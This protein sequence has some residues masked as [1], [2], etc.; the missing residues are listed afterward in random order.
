MTSFSHDDY[1]RRLVHELSKKVQEQY[2]VQ[3]KKI[4]AEFIKSLDEVSRERYIISIEE[5]NR[6]LRDS[7]WHTDIEKK[8]E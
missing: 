1:G 8:Q 2:N 5:E 6:R 4:D 3:C 7:L